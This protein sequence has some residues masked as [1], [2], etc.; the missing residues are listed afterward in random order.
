[1]TRPGSRRWF[2]VGAVTASLFWFSL[3]AAWAEE[4]VTF[5]RDPMSIAV[6]ATPPC[7]V[8]GYSTGGEEWGPYPCGRPVPVPAPETKVWIE[9]GGWITHF[10][11]PV[12]RYLEQRRSSIELPLFPGGLVRLGNAGDLG[13]DERLELLF[14]GGGIGSWRLVPSLIRPLPVDG[15]V[16]MPAGSQSIIA[17][18]YR[19]AEMTGL[20]RPFT[21]SP[22]R[23]TEVSPAAPERGADLF[24]QFEWPVRDERKF[25]QP[26]ELSIH[27]DA[28]RVPA[29]YFVRG[30]AGG[31]AVWYGVAP[32]DVTIEV[33]SE[34]WYAEPVQVRLRERRVAA[35]ELPLRKRPALEVTTTLVR[36]E[37]QDREKE[38][39]TLQLRLP[40]EEDPLRETAV[41]LGE[42]VRI[43]SLPPAVVELLLRVGEAT[44]FRRVDLSSGDDAVIH[45]ELEPI[46]VSGTTR[47][48]SER[49]SATV[50]F[51]GARF[52]SDE[53]GEYEATLWQ[54]RRY[55]ISAFIPD[56]NETQ[57]LTDTMQISGDL[58]LDITI[59]RNR[60]VVQVADAET[61]EPVSG[62]T[63]AYQSRWKNPE[64][65]GDLRTRAAGTTGR[66]ESDGEGRAILP[67][68]REGEVSFYVDA[69]GYRHWRLEK[70][71][72]FEG[73]HEQVIHAPLE[74]E[75]APRGLT[76]RLPDGQPAV[77]ARV[78]AL[79][80]GLPTWSGTTDREGRVSL[81]STADGT[82]LAVHHPSAG[83]IVRRWSPALEPEVAWEL[84]PMAAPLTVRVRHA[85]G[86]PAR[87]ASIVVWVD[88]VRF[89]RSR[90]LPFLIPVTTS[91]GIWTAR[92]LPA[93]PL[94]IVA[95][96]ARSSVD[97]D[98]PSIEAL[99]ETIPFPWPDQPVVR[100]IE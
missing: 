16:L 44:V 45:L 12:S 20:S 32:G 72:V 38:N 31:I 14:H 82:I 81:P 56:L 79:T 64:A 99:A 87:Q 53:R 37:M 78:V 90:P 29:D 58:E 17:V 62:A 98:A 85:D 60:Y 52:E 28:G 57:P 95:L 36:G 9:Q 89:G 54:A 71:S 33:Q 92:N 74:R 91:D 24:L 61:G 27:G 4:T 86:T 13:E 59:P 21:A 46:L 80:E 96:A 7:E 68:L 15:D 65:T 70:V 23:T 47:H 39:L 94:R 67:P 43:E 93:A 66:T 88:G 69:A 8:R 83:M 41:S 73:D 49:V 30:D 11:A 34:E 55:V 26:M 63:V 40:R 48:G 35:V 2:A 6:P 1:M 97:P 3:P 25:I 10:A 84:S 100:V 18:R 50:A 75:E 19:G 5:T 42:T 51:D 76:I 22:R 77:G